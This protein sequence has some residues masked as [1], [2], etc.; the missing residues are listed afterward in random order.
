VRLLLKSR[1]VGGPKFMQN[2]H[3]SIDRVPK[4]LS[5]MMIKAERDLPPSRR[6]TGSEKRMTS[7]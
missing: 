3:T 2:P 6:D 5:I 1:I 4:R 7:Q